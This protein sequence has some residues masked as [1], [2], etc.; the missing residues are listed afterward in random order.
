MESPQKLDPYHN[1]D[2]LSFLNETIIYSPPQERSRSSRNVCI[3]A[4]GEV[5]H[6]PTGTGVVMAS[7]RGGIRDNN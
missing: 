7:P 6:S 4:E 3:F 2:D 1:Q 5:D